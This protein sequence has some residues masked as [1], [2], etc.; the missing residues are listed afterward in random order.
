MAKENI[1][2]IV[3]ELVSVEEPKVVELHKALGG[4]QALAGSPAGSEAKP[5]LKQ[6][7]FTFGG[8]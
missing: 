1:R 2:D 7:G 8:K 5:S 6:S 3:P 4:G